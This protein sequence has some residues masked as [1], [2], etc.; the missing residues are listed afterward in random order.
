MATTGGRRVRRRGGTKRA[1]TTLTV[2]PL[3]ARDAPS[4]TQYVLSGVAF[5][6][7][8]TVQSFTVTAVDNFGNTDTNYQGT[9]HFTSSDP[10]ASLPVDYQFVP[11]D[12]GQHV[13]SATLK[14]AGPQTITGT[15]T[16]FPSITGTLNGLTIGPAAATTF[17]V[18]GFPASTA[19][20]E[21]SFTVTAL[22][23]Y[24]NTD[25]NYQGT[26]DFSSSAL[27]SNLPPPYTFSTDDAGQRTFS[28]QLNDAG[29]QSISVQDEADSSIQGTQ[30]GIV[31]SPGPTAGFLIDTG[32]FATR[33][34][35]IT[36]IVTAVDAYDN[37]TPAYSGTV[38][39]SST[40]PL[41]A[42]PGGYHFS[43]A[44]GGQHAFSGVTF[45]TTGEQSIA[46]TATVAPDMTGA[47]SVFVFGS[48]S[49]GVQLH[50]SRPEI[51]AGESIVL[52]GTLAL[53]NDFPVTV[54]IDWDDG[55]SPT[56]LFLSPGVNNFTASHTYHTPSVDT[57]TGA[58]TIHVTAGGGDSPPL[59]G[60]A[61]VIVDN[62]PPVVATDLNFVVADVGESVTL[63][64]TYSNPAGGPLT[65]T[66][67]FH[68][69][70][71]PQPVTLLPDGTFVVTHTFT[72]EDVYDVT[73]TLNNG[74]DTV[75]HDTLVLVFF[76][77]LANSTSVSVAPGGQAT[78]GAPG[79]TAQVDHAA[80]SSQSAVLTV[81]RYDDLPLL[82]SDSFAGN[83]ILAA[84]ELRLAG[85]DAGDRLT[86]T[87]SVPAGF[88]DGVRLEF[89]DPQ[90]HTFRPA[91]FSPGSFTFDETNHTITVV[92]DRNSTP[93][94]TGLHGTIF[95]I[96]VSVPE[97]VPSVV[98][99]SFVSTTAAAPSSFC[100]AGQ[101]TLTL[102]PSTDGGPSVAQ[103]LLSGERRGRA[104]EQADD[105]VAQAPDPWAGRDDAP[106]AG[107]GPAPA[108][109]DG[110]DGQRDDAPEAFLLWPLSPA[111]VVPVWPL[112]EPMP[113]ESN[114]QGALS[115]P[116]KD[117]YWIDPAHEKA[118][119]SAAAALAVLALAPG[120]M[121]RN[122]PRRQRATL[123]GENPSS[124]CPI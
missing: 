37:T 72:G 66:V 55:S 68:D 28:G 95:T 76:P 12:F 52:N 20:Q 62:A 92:F 75:S 83:L 89:Y 61:E 50:V 98:G 87:F 25:T 102:S 8:G 123:P 59:T 82:D 86:V 57:Q 117:D 16:A 84:Y 114:D 10:R 115:Q 18:T 44:D 33:G 21:H 113:Q 4:A 26:I 111:K 88:V 7:A 58:F 101:R 109:D 43:K 19:G 96:S 78:V 54:S 100:S 70:T 15:D 71:G 27:D 32:G 3:E 69:G 94:V 90:T 23:P 93:P 47:G 13:F 60:T 108:T 97:G 48:R 17:A 79:I 42:L 122:T 110:G 11:A 119:P 46:A 65:A 80:T 24:G 9:V 124:D 116:R 107:W 103:A 118:G 2:E 56:T 1:G 73:V 5:A 64:G 14:T 31:I 81:G 99:V 106:L 45:Q 40:D 112:T 77:A 105:Q 63:T 41:A 39:F 85:A 91:Q 104:E 34:I 22:D 121:L 120:L 74:V 51:D 36:V 30:G 49:P 6:T 67:N 53:S 35:P 38:K 29:T